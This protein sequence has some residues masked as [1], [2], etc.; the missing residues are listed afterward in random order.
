MNFQDAEKTYKDLKEQHAAGKLNDA[1]FEG[2]VAKLRLQDSQGR[3]WQVGVQTGE[4]YMH[5]GQK[6]NKAK[7]PTT[8]ASGTEPSASP[9][10]A[11]QKPQRSTV[12]PARLF[13]AAPA[14]RGGGMPPAALIVI[15]AVVALV[16]VAVLVGGYLFI[17]GALSG[18]S[19]AHVTATPTRSL[20]LLP[21]PVIPT[22]TLEPPTDTPLPPSTIGVTVTEALTPTRTIGPVKPTATKKPGGTAV[23]AG[24][25]ATA[26]PKVPPGVYIAKMRTDPPEPNPGSSVTFY[27]TFFNTSGGGGP[28]PWL[29]KIFKCEA[30]CTTDELSHSIGETPKSTANIPGG[31]TELAVGPWP[32]GVGACNFVA[33]PYYVDSATGQVLPF[34]PTNGQDRFY[35]NFK[36]CR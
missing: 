7:P 31:T 26:T 10:G 28:S 29:V 6:W 30:A 15:I 18:N 14:G 32:A 23:P 27:V 5:D 24:P 12:L 3:W 17:S 2:E 9:E 33:S 25:T 11:A 19:T 21:S 22:I 4:W 1:D 35:Y 20:A 8:P 36:L 16:G 34:A 13:S